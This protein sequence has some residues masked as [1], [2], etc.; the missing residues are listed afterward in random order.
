M[1]PHRVVEP[2]PSSRRERPDETSFRF[3]A[4]FRQDRAWRDA[5]P[6]V[7][8]YLSREIRSGKPLE[9]ALVSI[10]EDTAAAPPRVRAVAQQ[11]RG[12]RPVGDV[13]FD[14]A[15]EAAGGPEELLVAA[16][17]VGQVTGA[18]LARALETV[19]TALRDDRE[20]DQRRRVWL[21]QAQMSAAVLVVLPLVFALLS[22]VLRGG[23]VYGDAAGLVI[24]AV[25]LGLDGF[26]VVWIRRLLRRLR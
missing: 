12:G 18:P 6:S 23:F 22:S 15:V 21:A 14:W 3:F 11:L 9:A 20:L 26:G 1:I 19:A 10:V 2:L 4:R 16:L 24:L 13:L 25:G 5:L 8:L 7:A 17:R